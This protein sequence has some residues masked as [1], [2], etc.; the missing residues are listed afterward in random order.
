M[1]ASQL[2]PI[3]ILL[4]ALTLSTAVFAQEKE[5]KASKKEVVRVC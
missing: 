2:K 5:K 4:I 1:K 3:S